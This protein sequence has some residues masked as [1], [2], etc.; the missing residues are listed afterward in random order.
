MANKDMSLVVKKKK[1]NML[2]VNTKNKGVSLII[3]ETSNLLINI[4][5][6]KIA[7]NR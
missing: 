7:N 1:P 4:K 5:G 2:N 3:F 6:I